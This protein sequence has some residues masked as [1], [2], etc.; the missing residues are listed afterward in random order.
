MDAKEQDQ[1]MP[2]LVPTD[3]K[4]EA[5][6]ETGVK[7]DTHA[8]QDAAGEAEDMDTARGR[9]RARLKY[10]QA[11]RGRAKFL[12]KEQ[13]EL[14]N[15]QPLQTDPALTRDVMQPYLAWGWA[16]S[17][18]DS[19][20]MRVANPRARTLRFAYTVTFDTEDDE[21]VGSIQR[22]TVLYVG[23]R[24]QVHVLWQEG[25]R[26]IQA[27]L[28]HV[29]GEVELGPRTLLHQPKSKT[30]VL[31]APVMGVHIDPT[32]IKVATLSPSVH[33]SYTADG[34]VPIVSWAT[35]K[36]AFTPTRQE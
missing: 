14:L 26:G 9:L 32:R 12:R 5:E 30:K 25:V 20:G 21:R 3:V 16:A 10:L 19:A 18:K 29:N 6:T 15:T 36:A 1:D 33:V 34:D 35:V 22:I 23:V 4:T 17:Y 31:R 2:A 13:L 7:G 11:T 24:D 27:A 28:Q 8:V